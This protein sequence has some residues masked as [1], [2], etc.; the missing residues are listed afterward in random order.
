VAPLATICQ[1]KLTLPKGLV[2]SEKVFLSRVWFATSMAR[3]GEVVETCRCAASSDLM[4][5]LGRIEIVSILPANW[6]LA[7]VDDTSYVARMMCG[8][9]VDLLGQLVDEAGK[10]LIRRWSSVR[11]YREHCVSTRESS[12]SLKQAW[13]HCLQVPST[14]ASVVRGGRAYTQQQAEGLA[15]TLLFQISVWQHRACSP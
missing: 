3:L 2:Q 4:L 6:R 10:V 15:T 14:K 5:R 11:W 12:E 13:R 1:D 7:M 9:V 8:E